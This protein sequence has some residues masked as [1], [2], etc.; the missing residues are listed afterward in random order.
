M[1]YKVKYNTILKRGHLKI[2]RE[3]K[4]SS[5]FSLFFLY[6]IFIF[7]KGGVKTYAMEYRIF[8]YASESCR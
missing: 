6:F 5:L 1:V 2:K 4:R 8:K 7:F 3:K